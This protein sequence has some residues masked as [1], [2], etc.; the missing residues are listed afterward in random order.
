MTRP[1][2]QN[3][4]LITTDQTQWC[5][6]PYLNHTKILTVSK[7]SIKTEINLTYLN[8]DKPN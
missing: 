6:N 4:K 1:N 7:I 2:L 3:P 5:T 8:H